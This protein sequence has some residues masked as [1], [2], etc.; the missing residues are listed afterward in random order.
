MLTPFDFFRYHERVNPLTRPGWS[1]NY[2]K[3]KYKVIV[4]M[5]D[6]CRAYRAGTTDL[7]EAL[8]A[9]RFLE[10]HR[11]LQRSK[12]NMLSK[13]GIQRELGLG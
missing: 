6:F 11:Q 8:T 9:I 7:P 3:S 13:E 10:E 1:K 2:Q 5:Q 12:L 4:K